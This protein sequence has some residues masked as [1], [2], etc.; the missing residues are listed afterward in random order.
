MELLL[1]GLK[2]RLHTAEE[3]ISELE[4]MEIIKIKAQR[5]KTLKNKKKEP[6]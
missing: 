1:D 3:K 6:Q 4:N 2:S 5:E